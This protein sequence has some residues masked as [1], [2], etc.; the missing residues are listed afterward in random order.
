M[1]LVLFTRRLWSVGEFDGG[2]IG[3][4]GRIA[5]VKAFHIFFDVLGDV[6]EAGAFC[7]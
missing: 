5:T 7:V 4:L 1:L 3:V 6:V 2:D